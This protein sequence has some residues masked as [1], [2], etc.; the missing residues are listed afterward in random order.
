MLWGN[1]WI[2][3][4]RLVLGR[5][6]R[7]SARM[8][9]TRTSPLRIAQL[10][11]TAIAPVVQC[12]GSAIACCIINGG[13]VCGC[14][15]SPLVFIIFCFT[16]TAL[17]RVLEVLNTGRGGSALI[18]VPDSCARNDRTITDMSCRR[19]IFFVSGSCI[20]VRK[21]VFFNTAHIVSMDL[22][23]KS[24][25]TQ[26]DDENGN[27]NKAKYR[28]WRGTWRRPSAARL[29]SWAYRRTWRSAPG[30]HR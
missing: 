8:G 14:G 9:T 26:R 7:T 6:I 23:C 4:Y 27:E 11:V 16:S 29:R 12:L 19:I 10:V 17:P 28:P 5:E 20:L 25:R 18:L 21:S 22:S 13:N 2:T 1:T 30:W 24:R 3:D 15:R